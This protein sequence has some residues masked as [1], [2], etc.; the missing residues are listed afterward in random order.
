MESICPVFHVRERLY[1][2]LWV[3]RFRIKCFVLIG[4]H[5]VSV[6]V[7]D[8]IPSSRAMRLV[9]ESNVHKYSFMIV[10][11]RPEIV[12]ISLVKMEILPIWYADV[13]THLLLSRG[14]NKLLV[15]AFELNFFYNSLFSPKILRMLCSK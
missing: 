15:F 13:L 5:S 12:S 7:Y 8:S 1:G 3:L 2:F 9:I 6:Q 4:S 10:F 11:N 14:N